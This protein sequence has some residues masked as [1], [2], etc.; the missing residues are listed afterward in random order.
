MKKMLLLFCICCL[1][2]SLFACQNPQD[3]EITKKSVVGN[4][5][6]E[7]EGFGGPFNIHLKADGSCTYYVGYL[8]SHI[9]AGTWSLENGVI[10]I[11]EKMESSE[12]IFHFRAEKD[13]LIFI[14]ENS[15]RFLHITVE[16]GDKF[17]RSASKAD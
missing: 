6:W 13:A 1:C 4:Y 16:D 2:F 15:D 14:K 17:K 10:T 3:G 9:G 8:S 12:N 7:K 5:I 11:R